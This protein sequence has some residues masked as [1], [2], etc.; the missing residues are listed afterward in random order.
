MTAAEA[1]KYAEKN[2]AKMVDF[3]FIDFLGIWQHTTMPIAKLNEDVFEDGYRLRRLLDPRLAADQRVRH[4]RH[5]RP[6]DG[7]DR[8]VLRAADAVADLQH[9][10]PDHQ[11]ALHRD[12]RNIARK[13]EK[14]LKRPASPTR[15]TS[16]PRPSSSSSTTSASSE[17]PNRASY[18]VDSRRGQLEHRPRRGP[19][20]RLQAALQGRLLPG[21]AD[22]HAARPPH[23][24]G[25]DAR[26]GAASR[27]SAATTRSPPAASARSTCASTRLV[28]MADRLMWYKYIVKN[29]ARKH[30]KTAT[31]MPKPLFGDN[32]SGMHMP[33]V[34][35]EG[36][37]SRCSPATATR[38]CREM[39][40]YY[41]GGILKHA[42][43]LCAFTQPD[44]QQLQA[45]GA[46][47]RGAGEPG[48]L[49]AQPLGG[50]PH[51][52]R[53]AARRRRSA[54]SS[55]ARTRRATRTWRSP[56]C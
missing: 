55:A 46:G 2:G 6:G 4:A 14:Y 42:P 1:L 10:R 54:S 18:Y 50:D 28:K 44:H 8:S 22:R 24:D 5:P 16:A 9:R 38:A 32:G 37:A 39:A 21:A 31:F 13:A 19:E 51:P 45:A 20:P 17:G 52:D 25:A 49:V 12:P 23:R 48:V 11:A 34:A 36:R 56:R 26:G 33:P 47:L 41:I 7:D 40:L 29:V 30:G 15:R 43:A 35:L 53:T 27:S 3:K